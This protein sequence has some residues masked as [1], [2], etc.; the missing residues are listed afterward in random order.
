MMLLNFSNCL[1]EVLFSLTHEES[2][3]NSFSFTSCRIVRSFQRV[4]C[5]KRP[6]FVKLRLGRQDDKGNID[7]E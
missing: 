6:A 1:F 5:K 2:R 3:E 4:T 7:N